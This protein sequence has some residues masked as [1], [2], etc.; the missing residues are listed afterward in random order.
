MPPVSYLPSTNGRKPTAYG[1]QK[2]QRCEELRASLWNDRASFDAHWRDLSSFILP[3]RARF[4]TSDTNRGDKRN[5]QIIDSTATEAAGTCAAGMHS[6]VTS[7]ARPWFKLGVS[8]PE[9]ME[10]DDVK[11]Y[12]HD[13]ETRMQDQMLKSNFYKVLPTLYQDLAVFGT[14]AFSI[15][16]DDQTVFR[17]YDFPLGTYACANDAR[18]EVRTFVR[19][20]RLQVG[21]VVEQWGNIDE[22]GRPDFMRGEESRISTAVQQLWKR[23]SIATWVDLVHII[24]PNVSYDGIKIESEYKRFEEIY[25]EYGAGANP[26]TK[27]ASVGLLS[28]SGYDEFPVIVARW[29]KGGDDVYGTNCPGMTALGDI[30]QLQLGERRIMQAIEKMINPPLIAPTRLQNTKVTVLPGDVN[31]DDSREG[32]PGLR[33]MY[34]VQFDVSKLEAKQDQLRK[35]IESAFKADLFLLL[36]HD[37]S[38]KT[39]TEVNELKE[40]KLLAI[41][42]TLEQIYD[43][44]L[45]PGIDRIYGIMLRAGK[46]PEPPESIQGQQLKVEFISIMAQAQRM[47]GLGAL[48]RTASFV[49]QAAQF[50]PSVLDVVNM[51]QL[52]REH[53][54]ATGAPPKVL[55]SEEEV[56]NIRAAR[57]KQQATQQAAD[58]APGIAGALKDAGAPTDPNSP[59]A[60]L[61]GNQ[62]ARSTLSATQQPIQ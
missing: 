31:Y 52:V 9:L 41:G 27:D 14:G 2:R 23:E 37:T 56:A 38:D 6:G 33:A 15:M 30:K 58:N 10:Q 21:Q 54:E 61:L 48:E 20:F 3:R 50:E 16:E 57:Q 51:D 49:G 53:V 60:K 43:D 13:V 46:F 17:C 40:E 26:Y 42:P 5:N 28:H 12:L 8:D 55:N 36:S 4:T 32:S 24:Q 1:I 44:V 19:M 11:Q 59:L 25:Y 18:R 22:Y 47:L 34:Q 7:P 45:D 62:N 39:A 29:D 35:R